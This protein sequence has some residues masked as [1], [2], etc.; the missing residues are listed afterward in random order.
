VNRG[1]HNEVH[2]VKDVSGGTHYSFTTAKATFCLEFS[3]PS[4]TVVRG[5]KEIVM[6]MRCR[7]AARAMV[8]KGLSVHLPGQKPVDDGWCQA[9]TRLTGM[10]CRKSPMLGRR[11]C[12]WH[13]HLEDVAV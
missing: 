5:H 10:R 8:H 12:R 13:I 1:K 7:G 3:R 6:C 2:V 9:K 11:Y 4:V